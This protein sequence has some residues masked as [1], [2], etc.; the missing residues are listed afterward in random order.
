MKFA[1]LSDIH[2]NLPALETVL[3]HL[4][5][6]QA[7]MVIVNGDIVNRG[8][9]SDACWARLQ[10]CQQQAYW[11]ILQGNHEAY[12]YAYAQSDYDA[13]QFN[14]MSYWTYRQMNEQT[15]LLQT[16]PEKFSHIAPDHTELRV[17]HASMRHNRDGIYPDSALETVRPQ[18][19]PAPSVFVTGHTHYPFIRHADETLIVNIGSVGQPCDGDT[20]AS[21]AQ[22]TWQ[23][24]TWKADIVRLT[25]DREQTERDF[26]TSGF[27]EEA[28]PIAHLIYH[29]WH[30]A[31]DVLLPWL[32]QYGSLVK[33]G[34]IDEAAG[35]RLYLQQ[36]M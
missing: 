23:N 27:L 24:G 20:R 18:I 5:S 7:D 31:K 8:P 19:A 2:G 35:V 4:Q 33:A 36:I 14:A 13:S 11:Y 25:Y 1:I 12:V 29:E 17:C 30:T 3:D 21:Y 16:L 6:W 32:K 28:G 26:R 9:S 22:V 15:P 10:L 34:T